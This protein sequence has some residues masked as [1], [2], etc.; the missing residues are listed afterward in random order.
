M[1]QGRLTQEI[2]GIMLS[3]HGHT[4]VARQEAVIL[5]ALLSED[6]TSREF[7]KHTHSP[8]L[9]LITAPPTPI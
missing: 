4:P 8:A 7:V 5:Q 3:G 9:S 2:E 6:L 1:N